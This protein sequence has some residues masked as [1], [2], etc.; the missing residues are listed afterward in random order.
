VSSQILH[1]SAEN[2]YTTLLFDPDNDAVHV[3]FVNELGKVLFDAPL[4]L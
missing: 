3:R 4:T 2:A 1:L